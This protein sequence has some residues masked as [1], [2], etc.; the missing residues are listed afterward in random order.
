MRPFL[1]SSRTVVDISPKVVWPL[2][3]ASLLGMSNV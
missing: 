2:A 1:K 3:K